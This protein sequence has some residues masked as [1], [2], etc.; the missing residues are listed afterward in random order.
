MPRIYE[1]F[2]CLSSEVPVGTGIVPVRGG[3]RSG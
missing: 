3:V 2:A 1:G